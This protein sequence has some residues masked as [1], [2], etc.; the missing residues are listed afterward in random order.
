[1]GYLWISNQMKDLFASLVIDSRGTFKMV[2]HCT[3]CGH[4]ADEVY[5]NVFRK[6]VAHGTETDGRMHKGGSTG[7]NL[8]FLH[9][10]LHIAN[11]IERWVTCRNPGISPAF[12]V[13]ELLMIMNGSDDARLLNAWNHSLP[14]YL[15]NYENY[16]GAYGKRLRFSFGFDQLNRAYQVL[17]ENC[18]TRQV[19]LQIWNPSL[20][21]P[22]EDGCPQNTD[23]PCNVCSLLKIRE[24]KLM[25][26]QIMRSNDIIM[27]MPYNFI[28]FMSLQEII[29]GWLGIGVGE[30]THFSD[31][32]HLYCDQKDCYAVKERE[33]CL[34]NT[35]RLALS[36]K[37]SDEVFKEMFEKFTELSNQKLLIWQLKEITLSLKSLPQ[38]YRNLMLLLCEYV[39]V[40]RKSID[41]IQLCE[42]LNTNKLLS[43]LMKDWM[44]RRGID[45]Q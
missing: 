25:W 28:Q 11:P 20:D 44:M 45:I 32:L 36:K 7:R 22:K 43:E 26:T 9:V 29:A 8:E 21:M 16:P 2:D 12:A 3:V 18:N 4:T 1:M 10:C 19:V 37:D 24:N 13:A 27:G 35:D 34:L 33:T 31:S 15:G 40:K 38:A 6:L 39:A 42:S 14:I 41:L 5:K 23:I 30:Y 17:G